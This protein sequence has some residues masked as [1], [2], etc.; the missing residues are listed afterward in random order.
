MRGETEN[1]VVIA[2]RAARR[3]LGEMLAIAARRIQAANDKPGILRAL[4]DA[5]SLF[6]PAVGVFVLS[7]SQARFVTPGGGD[8]AS[9]V[10]HELPLSAAPAIAGTASALDCVVALR[11]TRQLSAPAVK[12]LRCAPG[13][14]ATLLPVL[15]RGRVTAIL[16]AGGAGNDIELGPLEVLAALAGAALGA[17]G[18][19]V[20]LI[21]I[22]GN[23]KKPEPPAAPEA[24]EDEHA[25]H[26]QARRTA[27]EQVAEI[28]LQ[29]SVEVER[30]RSLANLY[31][32]LKR[33]I[34]IR[35]EAFRKK[36]IEAGRLSTDYFHRELVYT[37]ANND[38]SLLGKN[39]PG[40]LV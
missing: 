38:E 21:T 18:S 5:A 9:L 25:L 20:D 34:D 1:A 22:D 39:Y 30:G 32:A 13:N 16:C 10:E 17:A 7:G 3:R 12:H 40:P 27:R 23:K 15:A 4:L 28:R 31:D 35:R 19:A 14:K 36:F 33:D 26:L 8:A 37:L 11:D 29:K 24:A 2:E 6:A